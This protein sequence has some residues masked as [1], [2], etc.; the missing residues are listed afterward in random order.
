MR[1][2]PQRSG[3]RFLAGLL[4][5]LVLLLAAAP[6]MAAGGP[7]YQG[8][9]YDDTHRELPSQAGYQ[10]AGVWNLAGTPA[11]V[12][13]N[14]QDLF[15][16]SN[17][18]FYIADTGNNRIVILGPDG[19]FQG[20]VGKEKELNGPEGVFADAD[21]TIYVA[22][23]QNR[24]IVV[25]DATGKVL[26]TM[27]R[28]TSKLLDAKIDYLPT[29]L[30]IDRRGSMYVVNK[31]GSLGLLELDPEGTFRGYFA[32]NK[33]AFDLLR[34]LNRTLA[35]K[36]QRERM[37]K[38][39]PPSYS[40]VTV[41]NEGFLFTTTVAVQ[42]DQIKRISPAAV[43][44]LNAQKP[45]IYGELLFT[46]VSVHRARFTDVAVDPSGIIT[47][48][49]SATARLYQYDQQGNAL[50]IFGGQGN[51]WG[52]LANPSSVVA[53]DNGELFVLD[54]GRGTVQLYQ[55]T[56]F[57][58]LV[59]AASRLHFEGK[60]SEAAA[61]WQEVLR[62]NSNYLLAHRGLAK[63]YLRQNEYQAAMTEF[64]LGEDKEG[65]SKA[66]GELRTIQVRAAFPYIASGILVLGILLY[67][68]PWVWRK[69]RPQKKRDI[70]REARFT[71]YPDTWR[72]AWHT[73]ANPGA[74][75]Y[76]LR[77]E[78]RGRLSSAVY[79]VIAAYLARILYLLIASYHFNPYNPHYMNLWTEGLKV[80]IPWGVWVIASYAV[81]T[82]NDGEA[83][84]TDAVIGSAYVLMPYIVSTVFLAVASN[85]LT[86]EDVGFITLVQGLAYAWMVLMGFL[87]I[88]IM[89]NYDFTPALKVSLTS[90]FGYG[91][92]WGVTVLVWS[93][94]TQFGKTVLAV[95]REIA[96]HG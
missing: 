29:K 5:A 54:A 19:S 21:G 53:G 25:Y 15:R 89:N 63:A 4:T 57:G 27:G 86:L 17:G 3:K 20:T 8:Y 10:A 49:D 80:L 23:T 52:L 14:P 24:R 84:F 68:A 78:D 81:A 65:Y 91:V 83:R 46:G 44:V 92:I 45:Q 22:D 67:L 87:Q 51:Q 79:L 70:Y 95:I 33:L 73:L 48:V 61:L 43:D 72:Q 88:K 26:R 42:N 38:E 30:V 36:E 94:T 66:F 32:P 41:D 7:P 12:L 82:I 47:G 59:Q 62:R 50:F 74:G 76:E 69:V 37:D 96:I 9:I 71:G 2:D 40:N 11:G 28:P 60:Y 64:Q 90:V 75:Y 77:Y 34:W 18:R 39:E 93:L 1:T 13:K 56:E 31:G 85:F 16:A 6:A 55:P 58:S 35:T